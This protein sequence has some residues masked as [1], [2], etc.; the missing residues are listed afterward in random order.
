M[1]I[2][3]T[4]VCDVGLCTTGP[5]PGSTHSAPRF[6]EKTRAHAN[7]YLSSTWWRLR[8]PLL[9]ALKISWR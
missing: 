1:Y 4:A 6:G 9:T 3:N 8:W 2:Y 7:T 5:C